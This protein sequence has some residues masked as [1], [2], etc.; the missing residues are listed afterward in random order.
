MNTFRQTF[1]DGA[2]FY[3]LVNDAT[4]HKLIFRFPEKIEDGNIELA[5]KARSI[6]L[7]AMRDRSIK[8]LWEED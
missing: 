7:E 5:R 2:D 6:F 4:E 1:Q 8:V 3:A